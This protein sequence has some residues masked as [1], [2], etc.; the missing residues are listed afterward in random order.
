MARA[1]F[2]ERVSYRTDN[3][4]SRGPGLL[5]VGLFA[6]TALAVVAISVVVWL[7]GWGNAS[8]GTPLGLLDVI[9]R[10]ILTT[11]DTGAVGNYT[12]G[13]ATV[14]FLIAMFGVTL[15]GIFV[16]SILI[17][18]VVTGISGRLEELRKGR[19]RVIEDGQTVILGWSQGIFTILSELV[20]ANENQSR[21][22]VAVLADRDKTEMDD[23]IRSRLGDTHRTRIVCRSGSPID[24]NDLAIANIDDAKSVIVLSP[25]TPDP[26]A[27]VIKTV[28]AITNNPRRRSAPYHVVAQLRNPE[29][30]EVAT[31]VGGDETQLVMSNDLIARI[32]AQTCRQSGLS[33]VYTELLDFDGDEI[34]MAGATAALVGRTFG[35]SL[36][37]YEDSAVI[38]IV[39]DGR[40]RLNPP[41][42][43]Q[44]REGDQVIAIS[45]DDDTI[46][47]AAEPIGGV[48][49]D[50]IATAQPAPLVPERVL[51]LGWNWRA[52]SILHE[53]DAYMPAG[54]VVAVVS[55]AE[56][57]GAAVS[58]LQA[59]LVN[60]TVRAQQ[61]DQ[62]SRRELAALVAEGFDHVIVLSSDTLDPQRAD[63][64]TIITLV[65][66]RELIAKAERR[67]SITS[68][69]L[70][71][72]NR[73]L[74]DV[75]RADDFIVSDRLVNLLTCQLSENAHL[76]EVFDDLFDPEGS[77][78]Y[79]RP[80]G[81]YVRTG[82]P[83]TFTT[84]LEAAR[85]R[86]E[87]AIGY[88]S[89]SSAADAARS[90]G[91]VLNP[92]K[93]ASLTLEERDRVIVLAEQG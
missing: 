79:L 37:W 64:R 86:N 73:Q 15:V 31:I 93:S 46:R 17:G 70:D 2:R 28:L 62:T 22:A 32:I 55:E 10:A 53:L 89:M 25:E 36:F 43:T 13:P 88:R 47:I 87:V 77:E 57:P 52:E 21:S 14:G 76:K 39:S 41:M 7:L 67:F 91:V 59:R 58:N 3:L 83:M 24:V 72:R 26:D 19:S 4:L 30:L 29:S 74:A 33:A 90:Y 40:V 51:I 65:H 38:G 75:T 69:I 63:T 49:E 48:R 16:T 45:E 80:A 12:G 1:T 20:I 27:D 42:D 61:G 18:I 11:I 82:Q 92:S 78:I 34:Y 56:V 35:E 54:S 9:W 85:R 71:L 8:G 50:L 5:I 44:I 6:L 81:E 84:I 68:E 23:E 60:T 66:L